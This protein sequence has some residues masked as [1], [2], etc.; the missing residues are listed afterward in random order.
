MD[1]QAIYM[2][3][4]NPNDLGPG[5]P[6]RPG[7]GGNNGNGRSPRGGSSLLVRS[8]IIVG[9]MPA[10]SVI[11]HGTYP[12]S[13]NLLRKIFANDPDAENRTHEKSS[14]SG[15]MLISAHVLLN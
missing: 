5:G 13:R 10:A 7:N 1:A 11:G 9:I 4:R 14:E 12:M 2:Y 6:Q 8:L 3:Q 15:G